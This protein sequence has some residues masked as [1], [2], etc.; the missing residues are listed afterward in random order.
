MYLFSVTIVSGVIMFVLFVSELNYYLT[1][2]IHQELFVDTSRGQ[3]LKINIDVILMKVGCM[4]KHFVLKLCQFWLGS[5]F[6]KFV[7]TARRYPKHGICR[8]RVS[9]CVCV[10]VTLR[11]CI[12]TAKPKIMQITPHD[13]PMTLVLWCQRSWRN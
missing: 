2:D 4:C 12:K 10:S 8:R 13:T 1:K 5:H 9:V 6:H 7:F 11:Y 3:K